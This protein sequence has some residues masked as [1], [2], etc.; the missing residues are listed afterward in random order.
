MSNSLTCVEKVEEAEDNPH[1]LEE[2]G[3]SG[4]CKEEEKN[5]IWRIEKSQYDSTF[6]DCRSSPYERK[7]CLHC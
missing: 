6:T 5:F 1:K 7:N 2:V 3:P 4:V